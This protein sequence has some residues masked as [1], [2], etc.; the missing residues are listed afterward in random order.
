MTHRDRCAHGAT[1]DLTADGLTVRLG[2]RTV[3]DDV[4]VLAR[5][6]RVTGLLGPNG[7]G[8]TTLLHVLAGLRRPDRG[9]VLVGDVAVRTL[10]HRRRARTIALVEQHAATTTDL[11]VRQVVALGRLPHRRMLGGPG[12]DPGAGVVDDVLDLVGLNHLA[13]RGWTTL[14]GG[15]RQRAHLARTL[16]Q[17]PEVLLLDEPTNHLDLGQQLRFLSLA[18]DLGLTTVAALHDLELA[19]AF[20]DDVVVLDA[21]RVRGRGPV[22]TTLTAPLLREVYRVEAS[23]DPHPRLD[24]HHLVWDGHVEETA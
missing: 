1:P 2:D 3:L 13:D 8:K 4:H 15:E 14:S 19:T 11:T 18:R 5:G 24:R 23:I 7:S 10:S 12:S 6:G 20:C 22:G 17:Q 9:T 16:A 21:G